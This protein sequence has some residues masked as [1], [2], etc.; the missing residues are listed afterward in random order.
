VPSTAGGAGGG[1]PGSDRADALLEGAVSSSV[2]EL[3]ELVRRYADVD[4]AFVGEFSSGRR[5]IRFVRGEGPAATSLV[6]RSHELGASYCRLIAERDVPALIDDVAEHPSLRALPVT[7][8]LD[9]ASYIGV[10]IHL[11]GGEL[12]G[13]LCG[14]GHETCFEWPP[15]LLALLEAVAELVAVRLESPQRHRVLDVLAVQERV[16]AA[17]EDPASFSVVYQPIV[18]LGTGEPVG[19]EALSRFAGPDAIGPDVW[20]ADAHDAGLGVELERLAARRALTSFDWA[21]YPGFVSVNLSAA[22]LIDGSL[23][24]LLDGVERGRVV[25]ELTESRPDHDVLPFAGREELRRRDVRLAVDDLGAGFAGLS[26]LIEIG[27]EI[28]KLD[29]FLTMGVASDPR[30]SA[31]AAAA[32][33]LCAALDVDLVAEGIE[34]AQD[35]DALVELGV[36][37]G[38]GYLLGRPAPLR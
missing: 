28:I 5:I 2:D 38:Q 22:A 9:I 4:V 26:R 19:H 36:G 17:L 32:V 12:Y 29:R 34:Q 35:R 8:E 30:R 16:H 14:F 27:P 37:L 20:F 23:D 25:V 1:A 31:L 11:S 18:D 15:G 13:T 7:A 21:R 6:G 3:L 24:E 10:P 33:H